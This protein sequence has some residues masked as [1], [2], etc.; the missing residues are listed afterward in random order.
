MHKTKTVQ[1][2][3][4]IC[5]MKRQCVS[6]SPTGAP[7][8]DPLACAVKISLKNPLCSIIV[9]RQAHIDSFVNS[10]RIFII[11]SLAQ[12]FQSKLMLY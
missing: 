7:P 11:L 12:K 4:K 3:T 1:N 10:Q 8:L 5:S 2:A 9:V 6:V